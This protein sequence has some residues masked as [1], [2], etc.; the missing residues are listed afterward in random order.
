METILKIE[1]KTTVEEIIEFV[2]TLSEEEQKKLL[3]FI[4]G[5]QFAKD[6]AS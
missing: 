2:K 3:S 4:Q 6:K 5:I 1:E